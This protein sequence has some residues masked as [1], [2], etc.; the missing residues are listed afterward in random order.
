MSPFNICA[1][2]LYIVLMQRG[3]HKEENVFVTEFVHFK[4]IVYS[5]SYETI[6]I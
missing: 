5:I 2:I 3:P 1:K 6:Y 4:C